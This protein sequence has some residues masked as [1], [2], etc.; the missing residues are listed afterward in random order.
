MNREIVTERKQS[1]QGFMKWAVVDAATQEVIRDSGP[2]WIPNLILNNGLN[3]VYSRYWCDSFL[4]AIAGT[5]TTPTSVDSNTSMHS[6][7]GQ[8][9]HRVRRFFRFG[10]CRQRDQVGLRRRGHDH[11]FVSATSVTVATARSVAARS[12]R[13]V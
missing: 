12:V 6:Q 4:Y 1:A 11:G 9:C 13:D 7:A 5:G 3:G 2:D 10:R 8:Q